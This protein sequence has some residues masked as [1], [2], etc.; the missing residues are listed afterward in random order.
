MA[1]AIAAIALVLAVGAMGVA[2]RAWPRDDRH[3]RPRRRPSPSRLA[4]AVEVLAVLDLLAGAGLGV[5]FTHNGDDAASFGS[6]HI[7]GA[8]PPTS[9]TPA[10]G[11]VPRATS[12]SALSALAP[13][14]SAP[15]PSR[16]LRQPSPKPGT[17]AT[18]TS[19]R[20]TVAPPAPTLQPMAPGRPPV[21]LEISPAAG[22]AGQQV[23]LRGRDFFSPDGHITVTFGTAQ[24][25][26]DCPSQTTCRATVPARARPYS[27]TVPVRVATET[28]RSNSLAFSYA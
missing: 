10:P 3:M 11:S 12:S 16:T 13:S 17:S 19:G 15:S 28:G 21:L 20:A 18:T 6:A 24:A 7:A 9:T 25:P 14:A 4:R 1:T 27:A 26:V 22:P 2:W 8:V 23:T 5:S